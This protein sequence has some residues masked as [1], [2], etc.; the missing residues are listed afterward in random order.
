MNNGKFKNYSL[1]EINSKKHPNSII[2]AISFTDNYI[3]L[4]GASYRKVICKCNCG[5]IFSTIVSSIT[6]HK[7]LSCGC[8]RIIKAKAT[9]FSIDYINYIKPKNSL[10][11]ALN[12]MP[13]HITKGGQR[14]KKLNAICKC[15]NEIIVRQGDMLNGH[16]LSCG[17]IAKYVLL[18]RNTKF[19]KN[20]KKLYTCYMSMIGRCYNEKSSS[21]KNYGA[22][23]VKV[24]DEWKNS[25]ESFMNW[26]LANGWQPHLQIDKDIKGD[27]K[28]YSPDTCMF[29]TSKVNSNNTRRNT[30]Y[31]YNG[32]KY[33]IAQL[34]ILL[35]ITENKLSIRLKKYKLT[36]EE[37]IKLGNKNLNKWNTHHYRNG[38]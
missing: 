6:Q 30:K 33:T 7:T 38:I 16:T 19:S 18:Q 36:I 8:L 10:L 23:D 17:C 37:I 20:I 1:D 29:V 4:K 25:Y 15:G 28:L 9:S 5:S 34:S 24:C 27:G 21:Y 22:R 2:T 35:G 31:E 12:H 14:V 13:P 3:T 26:S 32:G 11:T